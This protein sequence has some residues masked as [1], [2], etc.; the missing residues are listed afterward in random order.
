MQ[1][2]ENL[3]EIFEVVS[4][5]MNFKLFELNQKP[6]TILSLVMFIIAVVLFFVIS[7]IFN[8][9]ILKSILVRFDIEKGIRF[10][11]FF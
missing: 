2:P 1:L 7:R 9:L 5:I 10:K 8:R 6:I 3:N 11:N 4:S